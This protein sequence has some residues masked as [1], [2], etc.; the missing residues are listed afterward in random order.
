MTI[1]TPLQY[2]RPWPWKDNKTDPTL[3]GKCGIC[4]YL[5][6]RNCPSSR[7]IGAGRSG[8]N[9]QVSPIVVSYLETCRS[10]HLLLLLCDSQIYELNR[11]R[12][13]RINR[14]KVFPVRVVGRGK[15][16]VERVP[17][18]DVSLLRAKSRRCVERYV[19][20]AGKR[21]KMK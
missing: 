14:W 16:Q 18:P 9:T 19:E 17:R 6:G 21:T 7:V 5:D 13:V 12:T 1:L 8:D 3:R 11:V 10:R 4:E 2:I 15:D 20:P